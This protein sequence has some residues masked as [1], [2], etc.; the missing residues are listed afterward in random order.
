M[1]VSLLMRLLDGQRVDAL[2]VELATKL[3]VRES[4]APPPRAEPVRVAVVAALVLAGVAVGAALALGGGPRER[5]RR[6]RGSSSDEHG[7]A[8]HVDAQLVNA[9]G[10]AASP[11][12]PWWTANE[13]SAHEHALL[14]RR[15]A[16]SC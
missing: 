14:R 9:W 15:D 11:T 13:A 6:A 5:V 3:V 2:R 4:T 7:R 10:L 16:S 1:G 12:G 8:S